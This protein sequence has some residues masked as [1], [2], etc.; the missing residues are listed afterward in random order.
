MLA[1][2]ALLLAFACVAPHATAQSHGSPPATDA[3]AEAKQFDFLV[4]EWSVEVRPKVSSLAAMVHG[5]P[6]LVGTWKAW[7]AF[8]GFG[9]EDELRIVDASGNPASLSRSWR[10][11]SR[12]DQQWLVGGVDVYRGRMSS[13]RGTWQGNAMLVEAS[14]TDAEGK[15]YAVRTRFNAI[16]PD[17]FELVQ[18]RSADGGKTWDEGVLEMT[19][20]RTAAQAT[21]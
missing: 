17:G 14:G 6:R 20:T 10:V 13:A 4:G 15:P 7:R 9:I 11:Y 12:N 16:T 19:A 21:R 3:P 2:I 1:R 18:D 5:A 8:D